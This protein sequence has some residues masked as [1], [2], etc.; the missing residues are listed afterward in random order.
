MFWL[1]ERDWFW[2]LMMWM[3]FMTVVGVYV[4]RIGL[5]LAEQRAI[6]RSY[7]LRLA[8]HRGR[9]ARAGAEAATTVATTDALGPRS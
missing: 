4:I 9:A 7:R 3:A 8:M 6:E 2:L 1:E 5:I